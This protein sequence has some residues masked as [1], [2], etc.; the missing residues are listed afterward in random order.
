MASR[1]T[2]ISPKTERGPGHVAHTI[3]GSTV[4]Y[5]SDSLASCHNVYIVN[6]FFFMTDII[7][8]GPICYM[9]QDIGVKIVSNPS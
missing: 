1:R 2:K 4:G 7:V 3:F 6:S 5:P 9:F 8:I